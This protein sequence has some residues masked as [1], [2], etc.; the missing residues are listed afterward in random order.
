MPASPRARPSG[1]EKAATPT[2]APRQRKLSLMSLDGSESELLAIEQEGASNATAAG[3]FRGARPAPPM[4]LD[5]TSPPRAFRSASEGTS[6]TRREAR[7]KSR[8]S[9][10]KLSDKRAFLHVERLGFDGCDGYDATVERFQGFDAT[11]KPSAMMARNP[12][13]TSP[14]VNALL[15]EE[16]RRSLS[17]QSSLNSIVWD[18]PGESSR[19][20][21]ETPPCAPGAFEALGSLD[22]P[23]SRS[24]AG[25]SDIQSLCRAPKQSRETL[26]SRTSNR[27][28]AASST[29]NAFSGITRNATSTAS[30]AATAPFPRRPVWGELAHVPAWGDVATSP[31]AQAQL[32]G[33]AQEMRGGFARGGASTSQGMGTGQGMDTGVHDRGGFFPIGST[34]IHR[35]S[36]SG[37]GSDGGGGGGGGEGSR[38]HSGGMP[39]AS[40]SR[41]SRTLSDDSASSFP[42][43]CAAMATG[44]RGHRSVSQDASPSQDASIAA[45]SISLDEG[46]ISQDLPFMRDASQGSI[47]QDLGPGA[48]SSLRP[49]CAGMSIGR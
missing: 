21:V 42:E 2:T 7:L 15:G 13:P 38:S 37:S 30:S 18:S 6:A 9:C 46:S 17:R 40:G 25:A 4:T 45:G 29:A 3:A 11:D 12:S 39:S 19:A 49:T 33:V 35:G 47:S 31:G 41:A 20:G 36:G 43:L 48:A 16:K 24:A 34:D 10:L 44:R 28:R 27:T 23:P 14:R 5:L 32:Q 1:I 22:T 26:V 8:T